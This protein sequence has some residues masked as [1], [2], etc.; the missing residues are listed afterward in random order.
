[1]CN[2]C[3]HSQTNKTNK[4]KSIVS[5][6]IP[7]RLPPLPLFNHNPRSHTARGNRPLILLS[8]ASRS[9]SSL[10]CVYRSCRKR[11]SLLFFFFSFL[12]FFFSLSPLILF[13]W[14]FNLILTFLVWFLSSCCQFLLSCFVSLNFSSMLVHLILF[15]EPKPSV[16][17][18]NAIHLF[19]STVE[20]SNPTASQSP[21]GQ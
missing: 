11:L 14:I 13:H 17:V 12:F 10:S 18:S 19:T 7:S 3:V 16:F 20:L 2:T 15:H 21:A 4:Q 8:S 1:M 6:V 5:T 9:Q